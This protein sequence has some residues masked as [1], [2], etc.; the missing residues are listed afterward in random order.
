MRSNKN[1]FIRSLA[2]GQLSLKWLFMIILLPGILASS[3]LAYRYFDQEHAQ[4]EQELHRTSHTLLQTLDRE[5]A[6]HE[7]AL[8][9]LA[10]SHAL[11]NGD[12][13]AFSRRAKDVLAIYPVDSIILTTLDGTALV[14]LKRQGDEPLMHASADLAGVLR[15]I[16]KP[17]VA[18]LFHG[19]ATQGQTVASGVPVYRDGI[20]RYLLVMLRRQD[21]FARLLAEQD[22]PEGWIASIYDNGNR[23]VATTGHNE[24]HVGE[25]V[26]QVMEDAMDVRAEGLL[27]HAGN[28]TPVVGAYSRSALS[29]WT[30]AIGVPKK[31]VY[32]ASLQAIATFVLSMLAM[33]AFSLALGWFFGAYTVRSLRHLGSAVHKALAGPMTQPL[34]TEGPKEVVELAADFSKM[35]EER[36]EA[37]TSLREREHLYRSLFNNMLNG[38]AYCRM[39]YDGNQL[40]DFV[41]LSVNPAFEKQIR[42]KDVVGRRA[43]EVMPGI[44]ENDTELLRLYGRV[45]RT[46]KPEL[47]ETYVTALGQWLSVAVYSPERD[48]FVAIFEVI[49]ER[50]E[51][52]QRISRLLRV[53]AVLS[54]INSAIVRIHERQA[55][56]DA[57]CR[58]AV[59]DGHFDIAW[60]GLLNQAG[61]ILHPVAARGIDLH[62]IRDNPI[63][64][65][66]DIPSGQATAYE[67]L[68]SR[69]AV[70]C[71]DIMRVPYSGAVRQIARE[72]G[73]RSVCVLPLVVDGAG[74]G[75]M[76]LYAAEVDFFDPEEMRLLDE[77]AADISFALQYIARDERLNYLACYDALTGLPNRML[78]LDRLTQ[79]MNGAARGSYSVAT[80]I[81]D[82][83]RFTYI[84]ETYG[85]HVGDTVLRMVADRLRHVV[86]EP[87][88]L[89]RI[90]ADRFAVAVSDLQQG[91]EAS[92][93][94]QARIF[95]ALSQAFTVEELQLHISVHAGIALFPGDGDSAETLIQAAEAAQKEA[96][97]SGERYLY[98][99]PEI[100]TRIAANLTLERELRHALEDRQLA[101]HL[102]PQLDLRTGH[103]AGAEALLR[104]QHPQR[105]LVSPGDFIPLA[106]QTGLIV[107]IGE[108]V[109]DTVC[110]Q[111]AAWLGEGLDP[112]RIAVNLSP[113]Q[114]CHGK[115]LP[116]LE[117]TL[118]RHSL[119]AKHLEL[120]LT[121]GL[122]MRNPDEAAQTMD[123]LRRIGLRIA[124]D[125]FGTGYS[126][127]AYLRRFPFDAVKIDRAFVKDII[128]NPGDAAIATAIIAMAHRL[129]LEV[130]AEGVETEGQLGFL[131][132]NECDHIQGYYYSPAV[133]LEAFADMLRMRKAMSF[134][135][136][137]PEEEARTLL[138]VE[139]EPGIRAA[140]QRT[141]MR[142]GYRVLEATNSEEGLELLGRHRVQ[143]IISGQRMPSMSGFEFLS[144]VR[145]L[146]PHTARILLSGHTDLQ[147]IADA[148]NRG[149]VYKFLTKPLDEDLLK[150]HVRDAF[151]RSDPRLPRSD[152][153]V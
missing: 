76:A 89:A 6:A 112:V 35:L 41:F 65:S 12:L 94:V 42:L 8:L 107:P 62:A 111:Q 135:H 61:N 149:A 144:I 141:L 13:P 97:S 23:V 40:Q 129:K 75:V 63:P 7:A 27:H 83:D 92:S 70:Y 43:S 93:I 50:K 101:V 4:I 66:G 118:A 36:K 21:R 147:L 58:V 73:Y 133:P 122:V 45:A 39:L 29:G 77:L 24:H 60:I 91:P 96:Q 53:H 151:L 37:K 72:I 32:S 125:D 124:L 87:C 86:R 117:L 54:G 137:I 120:E 67:A 30:V 109:I 48:H 121:E 119:P 104:W 52:Q 49:S 14:G 115:L 85:R 15:Q 127:L 74:I 3:W 108:W 64:T 18:S 140:L 47:V 116:L 68:S 145:D 114:F 123:A 1:N 10:T 2:N 69:R 5:L 33:M 51:Q 22:F 136:A 110:A 98:Y 99:A 34:P 55:L 139:D 25:A 46:G 142:E 105:G 131:R 134:G 9:L 38:F 146:H 128:R 113:L 90:G 126:S 106:E 148:I 11:D 16:G 80:L 100:N 95:E 59:E 132:R 71:N 153:R 102:Q 138:I 20:M 31:A 81:L 78:F 150:E 28:E 103:I 88:T 56:L 26:A 19:V 17:A 57:A 79:F 44:R 82:L 143:V 130:V 152:S 84:N